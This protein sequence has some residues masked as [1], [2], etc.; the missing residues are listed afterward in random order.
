MRAQSALKAGDEEL[1]KEALG[2]RQQQT[3]SVSGVDSQLEDQ[4][5]SLDKLYEGMTALESRINE[6]KNKKDQMVARARTAQS[7]K[8]V[9]DMLSGVTGKSST[10][11]FSRMEE[12]VE[13][14]EAQADVASDSAQL[15]AG[16]GSLESRFKELEA[17][18]SVDDELAKMK[19]GIL[20]GGASKAL[21][22]S[23]EDEVENLLESME[24]E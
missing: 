22:G 14:M 18:S 17:T 15:T 5:A 24:E 23:V 21:P 7:T 2:R 4:K 11:A 10:D 13:M 20:G 9:K 19:Q 16:G 1:A 8:K 3:D 6:S 12:K